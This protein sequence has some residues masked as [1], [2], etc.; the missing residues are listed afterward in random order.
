MTEQT[1]ESFIIK[2]ES[3]SDRALAKVIF[4]ERPGLSESFEKYFYVD[5]T[6]NNEDEL[7]LLCSKENGSKAKRAFAMLSGALASGQHI[8]KALMRQIAEELKPTASDSLSAQFG[9]AANQ[10]EKGAARPGSSGFN[11]KTENQ[12]TLAE[13]IDNNRVIFATGPA[14]TGKTHVAV[15]KA[16]EA[17]KRKQI[18]KIILVRPAVDANE[19]LGFLPGTAED[20]MAPFMR[21]IYDAFNDMLGLGVYKNMLKNEELE[22]ATVAHMRGRTFKDCFIIVDEAQNCTKEQLK[23]ALTR[24][25]SNSKMVVTGDQ[26]QVDLPKK[27]DSGLMYFA[28]ILKGKAGI[29]FVD[30]PSK[31]IVRDDIVMTIVDAIEQHEKAIVPEKKTGSGPHR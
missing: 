19:K 30:F 11:P 7:K 28:N 26:N 21:P 29:G 24:I 17:L 3:D 8:K 12:K 18:K 27:E 14:G 25:G 1:R 20:K 2:L 22:I 31:D 15:V 23:M 16:I 5:F 10:N 9:T 13:Q 4:E 6:S